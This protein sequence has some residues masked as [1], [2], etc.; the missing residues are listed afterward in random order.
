MH[1]F[2]AAEKAA[3]CEVCSASSDVMSEA[4]QRLADGA[5]IGDGQ[6]M[7]SLLGREPTVQ[8]D[9]ALESIL[10]IATDRALHMPQLQILPISGWRSRTLAPN[11]R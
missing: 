10:D 4:L 6:Q 2:Q 5:P 7:P 9:D 11:T 3:R 1:R 8:G